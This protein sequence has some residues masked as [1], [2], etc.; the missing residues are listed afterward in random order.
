MTNTTLTESQREVLLEMIDVQAGCLA[1]EHT[2]D[3]SALR[4]R[5]L[6]E[7]ALQLA[8]LFDFAHG[9]TSLSAEDRLALIDV[10]TRERHE[11]ARSARD[12]ELRLTADT[13]QQIR[14]QIDRERSEAAVCTAILS[15][16]GAE[17]DLVS[18]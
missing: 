9:I 10:L 15:L 3:A 14:G 7:Q 8:R 6:A 16:L 12:A 11:F 5:E 1:D 17:P 2:R 13:E 4:L 18:A